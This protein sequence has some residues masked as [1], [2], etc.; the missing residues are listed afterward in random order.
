MNKISTVLSIL[1]L[2]LIGVLFYLHF[3]HTEKLNKVKDVAAKNASNNF[4]IAYFDI[5]SLQANYQHYKDMVEE[6]TKQETESKNDLN[7]LRNSY[8][9]F[10]GELQQKGPGMTQAEQETAQR[11]LQRREREYQK[12]EAELQNALQSRQM[13]KLKELRGEIESYL[14]DYNKEKGY[15]YIFSYEPGMLLYFRDSALNITTDVLQG[16]NNKYAG[17]KKKN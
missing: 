15:A 8:Q 3:S 6:L 7:A 14:A 9:R 11:E 10:I 16:L 13:D 4:K 5:D 1:C 17:S 2:G 12:R